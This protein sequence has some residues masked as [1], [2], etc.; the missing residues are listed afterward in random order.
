MYLKYWKNLETCLTT[1]SK[2]V[3]AKTAFQTYPRSSLFINLMQIS[4]FFLFNQHIFCVYRF[5]MRSCV[6][7]NSLYSFVSMLFLKRAVKS[8]VRIIY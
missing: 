5:I 6:L 3:P 2:D 7:A 4:F 1:E 8:L